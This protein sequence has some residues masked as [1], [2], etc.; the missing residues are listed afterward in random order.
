MKLSSLINV[1]RDDIQYSDKGVTLK[2]SSP[3]LKRALAL[4]DYH[5]K[6]VEG[7]KSIVTLRE[8]S[9]D[10]LERFDVPSGRNYVTY[11]IE[12]EIEQ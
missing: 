4:V 11:L 10:E 8:A 9:N 1:H 7:K 3:S 6:R 5:I 2:L 12:M